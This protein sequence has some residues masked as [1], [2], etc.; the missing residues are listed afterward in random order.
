MTF[1][2]T[3]RLVAYSAIITEAAPLFQMGINIKNH[4][5]QRTE[6]LRVLIPER[7]AFIGFLSLE[8]RKPCG[9]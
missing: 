1:R 4:I 3:H 6:D 9:I 7:D 2:Y 5:G 8:I